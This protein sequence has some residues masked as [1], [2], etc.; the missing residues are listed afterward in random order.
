MFRLF[1]LD[2]ELA[3]GKKLFWYF[4]LLYGFFARAW[5]SYITRCRQRRRVY[6]VYVCMCNKRAR[7]RGVLIIY[8][9]A[10]LS[11]AGYIYTPWM[12]LISR[13]N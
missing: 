5:A 7:A 12:H 8:I 10:Y 6:K 3:R 4:Y 13:I 11:V 2:R 9:S 1:Y